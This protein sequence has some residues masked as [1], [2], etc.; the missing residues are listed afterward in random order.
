MDTHGRSF[1]KTLSWRLTATVITGLV[2]L[3]LTGR[4]DFAITVGLADTI[5]KFFL[6]YGHERMWSRIRFG[7]IRA[8]EYEI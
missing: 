5:V 4:L 7:R 3:V 6:Y 1:L 2:T 8:P